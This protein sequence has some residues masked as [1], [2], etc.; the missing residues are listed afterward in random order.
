MGKEFKI[1]KELATI[2][3]TALEL[4][5]VNR[6]ICR[7]IPL[8]DFRCEYDSLIRDIRNTYQGLIETLQPLTDLA[9]ETDSTATFTD[10]FAACTE[11][12]KSSYVAAL[13]EPRINAEYTFEKY[14]QFRKRKEVKTTYPPLQAAF[15]R[16]HDLIDKWI[17]N[18]IWLAMCIDV[19]LKQLNLFVDDV[20]QACQRDPEEGAALYLSCVDQL[21]PYLLILRTVVDALPLHSV[22][23]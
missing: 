14:L 4:S 12:F 7:E 13:S 22:E 10:G 16:F 2:S 5:A 23:D 9:A 15:V 18:D 21:S 6:L 20:A 3:A 8:G 1:L 19:V 11:A 17:D